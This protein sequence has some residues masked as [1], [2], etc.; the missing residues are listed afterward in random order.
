MTINPY[1]MIAL[2]MFAGIGLATCAA[3]WGAF[4]NLIIG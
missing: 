4:P 1:I 2:A 3:F